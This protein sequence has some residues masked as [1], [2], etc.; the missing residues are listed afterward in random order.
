MVDQQKKVAKRKKIDN[1]KLLT[2]IKDEVEQAEI[3][4]QFGFK[5]STQLKVAYANALIESGEASEIKGS[6]RTKKDK[7]ID[8]K[9]TVN[10]RGSLIIKKEII[11]SMGI[12]EGQTFETKKVASGIQLKN[13]TTEP[14]SKKPAGTA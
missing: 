11:V 3:L 2:M 7:P 14:S 6:G 5:T 12:K 1:K 13:V 10:S 4:K 9:V 8:M